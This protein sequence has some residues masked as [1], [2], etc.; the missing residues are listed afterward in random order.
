MKFARIVF[1]IASAYGFISLVTL[2]FLLE[3]IGRDAPPAVTHPEFYYGFLAVALLWQ[4]IFVLVA[5]DPIRYRPIVLIAI[6]EKLIYS[7]PV[8]ILFSL[9]EVS[10]KI[11]GSALV[12]PIFGMLFVA[13]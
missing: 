11:L 5:K 7:V 12:D 8:V 9:G 3:I 6:C 10:A 13:A 1:G 4:L 2:Y